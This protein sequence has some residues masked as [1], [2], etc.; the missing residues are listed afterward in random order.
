MGICEIS[1]F[2]P[3]VMEGGAAGLEKDSVDSVE[4]SGAP[5]GHVVQSTYPVLTCHT[6]LNP[7]RTAS[8]YVVGFYPSDPDWGLTAG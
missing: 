1:R 4:S 3:G 2:Y 6:R 8:V 7:T 5:D